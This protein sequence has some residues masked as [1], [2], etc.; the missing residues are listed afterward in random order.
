M[1]PEVDECPKG[2]PI[3][4]HERRLQTHLAWTVAG[5]MEQV[6]PHVT[7]HRVGGSELRRSGFR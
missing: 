1:N 3:I 4:T 2:L 5:G 6:S 7:G